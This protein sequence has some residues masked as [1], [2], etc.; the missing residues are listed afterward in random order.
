MKIHRLEQIGQVVATPAALALLEAEGVG[1]GSLLRRH[2]A[3]DRGDLDLHDHRANL[4]A[5]RTGARVFGSYKLPGGPRSGSSPR[6]SATTAG[7]PRPASS[8]PTSIDGPPG[9]RW[10]SPRPPP[11]PGHRTE[12][13]GPGISGPEGPDRAEDCEPAGPAARGGRGRPRAEPR[14]RV[15]RAGMRSVAVGVARWFPAAE[16]LSEGLGPARRDGGRGPPGPMGGL[17]RSSPG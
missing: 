5:L 8:R 16:N 2:M 7:G 4:D 13:D 12:D 1:P 6:R 9:P 11:A 14:I 10:Q 15:A 17:G 3:L